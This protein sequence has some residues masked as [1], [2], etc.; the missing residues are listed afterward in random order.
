MF[1]FLF[2]KI[3]FLIST[4]ADEVYIFPGGL[5]IIYLHHLL[6]QFLQKFLLHPSKAHQVAQAN[7]AGYSSL[8]LAPNTIHAGFCHFP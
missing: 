6:H 3:V 2:I 7:I 5:N 4:F 8:F 1:Y